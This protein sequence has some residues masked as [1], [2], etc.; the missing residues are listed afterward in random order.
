MISGFEWFLLIAL[1]TGV[2]LVT[3]LIALWFDAQRLADVRSLSMLGEPL[4]MRYRVL[5]R[6]YLFRPDPFVLHERTGAVA[7]NSVIERSLV[8]PRPHGLPAVFEYVTYRDQM[9]L[10]RFGP[11]FLVLAVRV[12]PGTP[13]FRLRPQG[14]YERLVSTR[15]KRA[16][17]QHGVP[18]GW[19]LHADGSNGRGVERLAPHMDR[20]IASRLWI[21]V[22]ERT[23]FVGQSL[24]CWQYP[25][26]TPR[27]VQ[28]LIDRALP[29]LRALDSPDVPSLETPF[30]ARAPLAQAAGG[31]PSAELE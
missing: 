12:R 6:H 11:P 28:R 13:G 31:S 9:G 25:S 14:F 15:L 16:Q 24:R 7:G 26:F 19:V 4:G 23:L 3:L 22:S 30:L 27:G 10:R 21:Q 17:G 8:G 20:L 5:G 2:V 1:S 29:V 18:S